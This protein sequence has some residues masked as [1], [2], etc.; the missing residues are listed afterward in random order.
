MKHGLITRIALAGLGVLLFSWPLA[1][2]SYWLPSA[3]LIAKARQTELIKP[4][5]EAQCENQGAGT[6]VE[7]VKWSGNPAAD[8]QTVTHVIHRKQVSTRK[9]ETSESIT[10]IYYG[11][12]DE[13]MFVEVEELHR[14]FELLGNVL[15]GKQAD[16]WA[17]WLFYICNY[18]IEDKF[19]FSGDVGRKLQDKTIKT[20]GKALADDIKR[21]YGLKDFS[22]ASQIEFLDKTK[23]ARVPKPREAAQYSDVESVSEAGVDLRMA[24]GQEWLDNLKAGNVD[25]IEIVYSD[26]PLAV[27]AARTLGIDL[28][29]TWY[30]L[31]NIGEKYVTSI[32]AQSL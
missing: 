20:D 2:Q 23:Y 28:I 26:N 7:S 14:A 1:A 30:N 13:K 8:V 5:I 9:I 27:I 12:Y 6:Y 22:R 16:P 32:K 10:Y 25:P 4:F 18:T 11:T 17:S 24:I 3:D 15:T 19:D 31:D 29:V 21:F